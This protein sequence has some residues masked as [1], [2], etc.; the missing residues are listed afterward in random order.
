[1]L[2]D[3]SPGTQHGVLPQHDPARVATHSVCRHTQYV[4]S[5]ELWLVTEGFV[6]CVSAL[7]SGELQGPKCV[8]FFGND[9]PPKLLSLAVTADSLPSA[10]FH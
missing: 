3:S 1:M 8:N 5:E 2:T 10:V 7:E 4:I 6:V 9:F